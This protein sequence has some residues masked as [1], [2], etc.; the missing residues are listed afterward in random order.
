MRP[1]TSGAPAFDS[2]IR[3]DANVVSLAFACAIGPQSYVL[4]TAD[5][6]W[7]TSH[8]R[9]AMSILHVVAAGPNDGSVLILLHGFP[10]FG[11]DGT[12]RS[13]R[14]RRRISRDRAR[15][16]GYNLSSKPSACPLTL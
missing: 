8:L 12:D 13:S 15:Q 4:W 5:A 9:M 14:C 2:L 11:M 10:N 6:P 1:A 3:T 7:K 16:R